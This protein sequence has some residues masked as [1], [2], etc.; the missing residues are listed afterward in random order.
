[1]LKKLSPLTLLVSSAVWAAPL[2]VPSAGSLGNQLRQEAPAPL[3]PLSSAPLQLPSDEH[4]NTVSPSAS[5]T[6]V[7]LKKV[8]FSGDIEVP[9]VASVT[10]A[11]LQQIVLPWVGKSISFADMQTLAQAVTQ[12]YR[13]QGILLGHAVLPPQTI[14]NGVLTVNIIAGRYDTSTIHNATAL[15]DSV[16]QRIV[17][18]TTPSGEVVRRGTLER[19]A[20]LLSEIPGVNAQVALKAGEKTGTSALDI[21]L[22]PGPQFGGYVGMDNQGN[23]STGRSRAM[24]GAYA[25][26]LLG[27]GDQLRVDV[28][29]AYEHSDLFN[30]ALDYSALVGGYG[31]RVGANYS[32]LN[33]HYNFQGLGFNGYSDNWTV[34]ATQPWIRTAKAR[35]DVRLD[36]GQ[37]YLTDKYP[38]SFF[39]SAF[40]AEGRKRVSL[41]GL[42]LTGTAATTPGGLSGIN[43]RGTV[44]Q[45]D[46]RTEV[47]RIIGSSDETG[48]SGQFSRL[49]YQ[50]NHDQQIWG[51][52]S[53][54]ANLTGQMASHNLDT[55][56]KFLLGGPSAVRAYDVGDG[57]VD[58]GNIGTA[59][60]RSRWHIPV[61][62]WLGTSPE[63]TVA[64]FYDQGWGEQYKDN[65]VREMSGSARLTNNNRVNLSG[66][67]LY[68]TV[69]DAG[70]YALTMTWAHRTGDVD[71]VSGHDDSDRFWVSAV[72]T[73]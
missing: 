39:S 40:G 70:N 68:A 3:V 61:Q 47:A 64:A 4:G 48:A 11:R 66:T 73:F 36:G 45:M 49:N 28:M 67:G 12:L 71:P 24:L 2:P 62:R 34:Y 5:Q 30:G 19:V 38:S 58:E 56:Q 1:M 32:H 51:P 7:V 16:V 9:G 60:L 69:A 46:Y 13:Q 42:S 37:Q 25:N 8:V 53:F 50:L 23:A 27:L 10:E 52:F 6:R 54:Y 14:K 41:G 33:Y 59:E 72:K 18:T 17:S 31:T 57:S 21:N 26:N 35:V 22:E 44:G 55:S 63:L 29:D 15:R 43:V 65:R 20:L